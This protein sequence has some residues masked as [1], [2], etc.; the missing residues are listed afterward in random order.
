MVV[1]EMG[2]LFPLSKAVINEPYVHW[3]DVDLISRITAKEV[4]LTFDVGQ[5]NGYGSVDS[6]YVAVAD[7]ALTSL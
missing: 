2:E 4:R 3:I 1:F 6:T 5:L 7:V